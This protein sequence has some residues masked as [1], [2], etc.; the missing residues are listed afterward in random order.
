LHVDHK[1]WILA[2]FSGLIYGAGFYSYIAYRATPL[3]ILII[4]L[5]FYLKNKHKEDVWEV[6]KIFSLFAFIAILP[7]AVYFIHNPQDFLGRTAQISIFGSS[8]PLKI[9][10]TNI[11][12]T[13]GMFNFSGDFNWR[14]NFSGNPELYWP[15]GIVFL[16]GIFYG[17]EKIFQ[18]NG[19]LDQSLFGQGKEFVILFSWIFVAAL[20][21]VVSNEGIP[22][23][24]R[25]ILMIPAVF[26]FAGAGAFKIYEILRNKLAVFYQRHD[27]LIKNSF[28]LICIAFIFQSYNYYFLEWGQ[29]QNVKG[30]FSQDYVDM[31]EMLNS[32]PK[33]QIKYVVVEANGALVRGI[34]MPSQTVM[35]IT[36]TFTV[37]KQVEKNI[38]YILPG[39]EKDIYENNATFFYLK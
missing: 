5:V 7:L 27:Q 18:K 31:G 14:H 33:D 25:S 21:V 22:H 1:S 17:I 30:A 20:S 2:A 35:F 32:L 29:N 26:V 13:A 28:I 39:Q 19:L 12:K 37:K 8:S 15:I 11:L 24:L 9:L 34:P 16:F 4:F 3:L 23:A 6:F 36:D 38:H 10:G